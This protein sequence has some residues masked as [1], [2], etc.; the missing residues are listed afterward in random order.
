MTHNDIKTGARFYIRGLDG[1]VECRIKDYD[2]VSCVYNCE[3][4]L[5]G[6]VTTHGTCRIDNEDYL[7]VC[8][9]IATMWLRAQVRLRDL[10][11]SAIPS[12]NF[13]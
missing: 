9:K 10:T 4:E 13:R 8:I 6:S 11:V 12:L 3:Y 5:Y 7:S 2:E 1:Q